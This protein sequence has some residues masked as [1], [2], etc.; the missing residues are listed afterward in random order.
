MTNRKLDCSKPEDAVWVSCPKCNA[1]PGDYCPV[2]PDLADKPGFDQAV[3][4]ARIISMQ[5]LIK[6]ETDMIDL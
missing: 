1:L 6:S 5:N 2:D 3:H 4:Q